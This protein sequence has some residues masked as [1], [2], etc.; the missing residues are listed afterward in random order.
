MEE[1][2]IE[3]NNNEIINVKKLDVDEISPRNIN[4]QDG[5]GIYL[6]IG[7][8]GS[9]K[10]NIIKSLIYAKSHFIP[11]TVVVSESEEYNGAYKKIVPDLFIHDKITDEYIKTLETRQL[12]A[13]NQKINNPYITLVLDD[14]MNK[15]KNMT[16]DGYFKLFKTGRHQKV[17]MIVA[18]QHVGDIPQT[19]KNQC[20]GV[21]LLKNA[22]EDT[23]KKLYENFGGVFA[24]KRQFDS[25]MDALTTDY[26]ALFINCRSPSDN[27]LEKIRWFKAY[28]NLDD[29]K[30]NACNKD[31]QLFANVRYDI[32]TMQTKTYFL[33][34]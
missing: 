13:I 33:K 4:D 21:F 19:L 23:R 15:R 7:P 3:Q 20:A 14:C 5:G 2:Y 32:N 22:N 30:W 31:V 1:S 25:A 24:T 26:S 17:Y 27:W 29:K 6:V 8:S 34:Q 11:S 28:D 12:I 9:G 16:E 18:M 10:T